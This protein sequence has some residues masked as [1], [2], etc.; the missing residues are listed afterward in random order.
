MHLKWEIMYFYIYQK[1]A[2]VEAFLFS[3]HSAIIKG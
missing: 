3:L 1:K 2:Y